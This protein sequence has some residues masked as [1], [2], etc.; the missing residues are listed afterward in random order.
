MDAPDHNDRSRGPA[1]RVRVRVVKERVL[2]LTRGATNPPASTQKHR[3]G[4]RGGGEASLSA[5]LP[6]L[7]CFSRA[8]SQPVPKGAQVRTLPHAIE[9]ERER[10]GGAAPPLSDALFFFYQARGCA[11]PV[12]ES[13]PFPFG[14][15][16]WRTEGSVC[17]RGR[18]E[19]AA[20]REKRRGGGGAFPYV[21]L[22]AGETNRT[23]FFP[24]FFHI[25]AQNPMPLLRP[26]PC[27]TL[28]PVAVVPARRRR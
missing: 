21:R 22:A 26:T 15:A 16:V 12:P 27:R 10:E 20:A 28:A 8:P 7:P 11:F 2:K 13:N 4:G 3:P 25:P 19:R 23:P 9:R 5:P 18:V 6:P 17:V 24:F 14:C 1:T